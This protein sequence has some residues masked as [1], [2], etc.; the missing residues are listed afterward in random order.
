MPAVLTAAEMLTKPAVHG[1]PVEFTRIDI[2][3]ALNRHAIRTFNSDRKSSVSLALP[4]PFSYSIIRLRAGLQNCLGTQ[5][6]LD[7]D[8]ANADF[9]SITPLGALRRV[10]RKG[11]VE[12][13]NRRWV[14]LL[15]LVVI[16]SIAAGTWYYRSKCHGMDACAAADAESQEREK[17]GEPQ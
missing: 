3:Q 17:P 13:P 8:T 1:G 15:L 16:C 14:L 5:I 7:L 6:A 11:C 4:S 9:G 2:L 10:A 12:M